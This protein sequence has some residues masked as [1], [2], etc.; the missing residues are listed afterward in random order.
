MSASEALRIGLLQLLIALASGLLNVFMQ[1]A[2]PT[3]STDKAR[4]LKAG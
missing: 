3:C 4:S 1:S 2:S